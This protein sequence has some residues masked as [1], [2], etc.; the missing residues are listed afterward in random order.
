MP[1]RADGPPVPPL[2]QSSVEFPEIP[3]VKYN[4]CLHTGD[5]FDFGPTFDQGILTIL[6]PVL[7]GTPYPVLVPKG[8]VDGNGIAGI[9]LPDVTVPLATYTGWA[10]RANAGDDGCDAAGQKIDFARTKAERLA[11]GD[12]RL[13][14]EERYPAHEKYVSA[15]TQ[16]ANDLLRERLLLD[17]DVQR[18]VERAAKSEIGK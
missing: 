2:P 6:P 14:I 3:G 16:A 4:G 5:W 10:L 9:R 8:D 11:A 17:E 12:P 1:H 18:Y 15:V 13:S 7:K